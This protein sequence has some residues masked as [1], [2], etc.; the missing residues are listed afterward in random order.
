MSTLEIPEPRPRPG[1]TAPFS[2]E[3]S[4]GSAHLTVSFYDRARSAPRV[5]LRGEVAFNRIDYTWT[6]EF[7][8]DLDA[9]TLHRHG[10]DLRRQGERLGAAA[11]TAAATDAFD[12]KHDELAAIVKRWLDDHPDE[13]EARVIRDWNAAAHYL[14]VGIERDARQL[15]AQLADLAALNVEI[16]HADG[17]RA[18]APPGDLSR[19]SG[20]A[21]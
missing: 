18:Q 19:P 13:L 4:L 12:E 15:R 5:W 17:L 7:S 10:T 11:P 2:V 16:D 6:A 21:G 1:D 3:T 8:A 9:G 20:L 14:E